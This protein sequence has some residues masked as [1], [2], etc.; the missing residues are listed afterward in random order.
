MAERTL[1]AAGYVEHEATELQG[2]EDIRL[3]SALLESEQLENRNTHEE[4]HE[5]EAKENWPL[6]LTQASHQIRST[7]LG[8]PFSVPFVQAECSAAVN[9]YVETDREQ[10]S[11]LQCFLI[12]QIQYQ[13][14]RERIFMIWH[15]NLEISLFQTEDI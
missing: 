6:P 10:F 4:L 7:L 15:G 1:R 12:N 5:K 3:G 11:G 14:N 2:L 9:I 13:Q 8:D